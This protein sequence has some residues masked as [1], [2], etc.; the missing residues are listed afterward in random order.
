[1]KAPL[2]AP[3]VT[4]IIPNYNHENY[5]QERLDSV[6]E[7]TVKDYEVII[8]DD[9]STD[10]SINILNLYRKHPKVSHFIVNEVNSGSPFKQWAKGIE[11]AKGEYIWIAES[12]DYASLFFLE[13]VLKLFDS[14]RNIDIVFSG[15]VNVDKNGNDIGNNTRIEKEYSALLSND[16]CMLGKD[17]L[18]RLLPDYCLIRNA[19]SAVFKKSIINQESIKLTSF[20]TIGDFYFWIHLALKGYNFS[21]TSQKL[22]YMRNHNKTVRKNE[23]KKAFKKEE[24]RRIHFEVLRRNFYNLKIIKVLAA[25]WIKKLLK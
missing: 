8:L 11:L 17:F 20:K 25:Y 4:V 16:F 14:Q 22:N 6:F 12:D 13:K 7:Q 1:M 19:S 23:Q 2:V 9:G 18:T 21:Y 5:L 10:N 3:L 24:Y 15:T